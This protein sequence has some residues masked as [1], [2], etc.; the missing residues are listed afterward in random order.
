MTRRNLLAVVSALAAFGTAGVEP[1]F[2]QSGSA[3]HE[4]SSDPVLSKSQTFDFDSLPVTKNANGGV[5]RRVIS[6]TLPTG[7]FIE[8]HETTLPAGQMPH[9]P[10]RHRNSE[11]LFIR[12][13]QLEYLNDGKP[14]HVGPGGMVFTASNVMHGLKNVGTTPASYFV[15]AISRADKE[16]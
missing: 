1:S 2:P 16:S 15:I 8:V 7:E 13:G 10:H 6:G 5:M 3:K 14:E 9:P 11:L 4:R 12:E